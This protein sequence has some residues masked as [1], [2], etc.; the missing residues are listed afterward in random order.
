VCSMQGLMPV[1]PRECVGDRR[2]AAHE[3]SLFD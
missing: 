2:P 1:V 3:A